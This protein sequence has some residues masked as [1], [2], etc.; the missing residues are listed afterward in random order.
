MACVPNLGKEFRH[1]SFHAGGQPARAQ[2]GGRSRCPWVTVR[3]RRFPSVLAHEWHGA[4]RSRSRYAQVASLIPER[5]MTFDTPSSAPGAARTNMLIGP[6]PPVSWDGSEHYG[7]YGPNVF[8][9]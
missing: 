5:D 3:D 9:D 1:R 7:S 8:G 4:C 6:V 2:V